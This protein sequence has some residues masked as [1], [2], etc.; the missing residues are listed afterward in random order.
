MS[1]GEHTHVR[2]RR[3]HG[4]MLKEQWAA[5]VLVS[6]TGWALSAGWH[7]CVCG[8]KNTRVLP[9]LPNQFLHPLHP[10]SQ[11]FFS[12]W[13]EVLLMGT[14]SRYGKSYSFSQ[15]RFLLSSSSSL[16][17]ALFSLPLIFHLS[18]PPSRGSSSELSLC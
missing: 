11:R 12:Y 15:E 9:S 10:W 8:C 13:W 5:C 18:P 14:K 1:L 16:L 17:F 7:T 2:P 3:V 6:L 4:C